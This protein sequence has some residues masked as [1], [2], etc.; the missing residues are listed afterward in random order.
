M[1]VSRA[2]VV[3]ES[4]ENPQKLLQYANEQRQEGLYNDVT[5]K[6]DKQIMRAN[7]MIL[8]CYSKVFER[9][10][11]SQMKEQY[12]DAIEIKDFDG[13]AIKLLIDF[14]YIRKVNIDQ[15]NVMKLL[16]ASH[17]L[18]LEEVTEFC[19]DFLESGLMVDNCLDILS[20]YMLYKPESSLDSVYRFIDENI[21]KVVKTDRFK[22]LSKNELV[23]IIQNLNNAEQASIYKAVRM[24]VEH[25]SEHRSEDFPSLFWLINLDGLTLYYLENVVAADE[26]VK[27]NYDC[28]NA[29]VNLLFEKLK[30]SSFGD[31]CSKIL[32]LGGGGKYGRRV[33]E[34]LNVDGISRSVYP[35]LPINMFYHCVLYFNN[36][37]Y[38]VGGSW[39][40]TNVYRLNLNS[41]TL[42][43]KEMCSMNEKRKR[44]GAAVFQNWIVVT[45]GYNE[46]RDLDSA[47]YF[48]IDSNEWKTASSMIRGRSGHGLVECN[49][50]LYAVGG[51]PTG[52]EPTVERLQSL[53]GEWEPAPSMLTSR[54]CMAA[55]NCGGCIY[56]VGGVDRNK[57]TL[58]TVEKF[59]PVVKQWCHVKEMNHARGSH[60]ACVLR[61]KIYVVGGRN[62]NGD[63]KVVECYDPANDTWNNVGNVTHNVYGHA[64]VA[65]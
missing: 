5:I 64:L 26:L 29:V 14:I 37:V 33:I 3:Y 65:L 50:Y 57:Q 63:V 62:N 1:P 42:K 20:A 51:S 12:Q 40:F 36:A 45:G 27:G 22:S 59:D 49:G 38:C 15:D 16:K 30:Q 41:P 19:F 56:A 52:Q 8:S 55:V 58:K 7:R 32:R 31:V 43:W 47:E 4:H 44:H 2:N 48:E 35:E 21:N 46:S 34:V 60:A 17:F 25:D 24:W 6:A 53:N 10:F 9:M 39:S 54:D 61:G 28:I 11:R 23:A 18:Q 13:E